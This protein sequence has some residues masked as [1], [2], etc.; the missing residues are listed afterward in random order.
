MVTGGDGRPR[1]NLGRRSI[2]RDTADLTSYLYRLYSLS[3]SINGIR[4][5]PVDIF[6]S[7][8]SFYNNFT[9]MSNMFFQLLAWESMG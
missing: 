1:P 8:I 9:Y 6:I 4:P 3:G 7:F 2:N 5:H